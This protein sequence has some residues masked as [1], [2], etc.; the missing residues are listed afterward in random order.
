MDSTRTEKEW[1]IGPLHIRSAVFA[2]DS[3]W[4]TPEESTAHELCILIGE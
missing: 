1:N 2:A 3:A 4:S